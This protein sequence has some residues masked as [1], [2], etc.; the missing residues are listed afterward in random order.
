[1][2]DRENINITRGTVEKGTRFIVTRGRIEV[3]EGGGF[4][5]L[6]G[7]GVVTH[8]KEHDGFVFEALEII[9]PVIAAKRVAG[10]EA[11]RVAELIGRV[12]TINLGEVEVMPVTDEFYELMPHKSAISA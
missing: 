10:T 2:S 7:G 1:M 8:S 9:G 12:V 6:G 4:S 5:F 11:Y 3:R